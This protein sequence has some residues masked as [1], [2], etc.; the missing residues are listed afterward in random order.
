MEA[1]LLKAVPFG[2]IFT[3][4]AIFLT[5][6]PVI[7]THVPMKV[8][9]GLALAAS[10]FF[11]AYSPA[12]PEL[13]SLSWQRISILAIREAIVGGALGLA[14]ASLFAAARIGARMIERQMGLAFAQMV[15]P[16]TGQRVSPLGLLFELTAMVIFFAM[17]G[18]HLFFMV[19]KKS[20]GT[21]AIGAEAPIGALAG[22]VL[23]ATGLCLVMALQLGAPV[24]A[25]LF[26]ISVLLAVLSR[27]IPEM[28]VM[29][30]AFPLRIG[31]GLLATLAFLPY[32]TS[33]VQD[34]SAGI[35]RV[36]PFL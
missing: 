13:A 31:L 27:T 35:A 22:G 5:I 21:F 11:T 17:K 15:D 20:Y 10:L 23:E 29:L 1:I 16:A 19:L 6:L 14:I 34:L 36:L 25:L 2:L 26:L 8:R 18:H 30:A 9:A 24:L 3:R 33:F 28:N 7:G 12:A 4:V 32:I